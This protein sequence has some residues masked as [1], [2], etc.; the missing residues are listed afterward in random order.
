MGDRAQKSRFQLIRAGGDGGG[1]G[2]ASG[3]VGQVG[4]HQSHEQ[5]QHQAQ[6]FIGAGHR[7]RPPRVDEQQVV[8]QDRGDHGRYGGTTPPAAGREHDRHQVQQDRGGQVDRPHGGF[9][10]SD[11][12][13]GGRHRP[14]G[15]QVL[16]QSLAGH[17]H[18]VA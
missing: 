9:E 7:K 12:Q 1:L 2:A 16:E 14:K 6:R 5:Q 17:C 4:G 13:Q 11:H 3:G 15:Q 18:A 10:Q 8:A